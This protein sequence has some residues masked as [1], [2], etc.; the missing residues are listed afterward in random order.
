MYKEILMIFIPFNKVSLIYILFHIKIKLFNNKLF[1]NICSVIWCCGQTGTVHNPG[2]VL[3]SRVRGKNFL[4]L[5]NLILALEYSYTVYAFSC[6]IF[7]K[8]WQEIH[9]RNWQNIEKNE[10]YLLGVGGTGM[11][12]LGILQQKSCGSVI[13]VHPGGTS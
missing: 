13:K 8:K 1:Q 5:I 12:Q 7:N 11:L 6:D 10:S 3:C 4:H 2:T 9:S